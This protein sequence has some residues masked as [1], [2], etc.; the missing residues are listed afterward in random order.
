MKDPF[1]LMNDCWIYSYHLSIYLL[2]YLVIYKR[3]CELVDVWCQGDCVNSM[4]CRVV[5]ICAC[6]HKYTHFLGNGL[7]IFTLTAYRSILL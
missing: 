6:A 4:R 1:Q 5:C 3:V 7:F 2:A